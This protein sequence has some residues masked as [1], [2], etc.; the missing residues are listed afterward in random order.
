MPIE[1]SSVHTHTVSWIRIVPSPLGIHSHCVPFTLNLPLLPK[2]LP[3]MRCVISSSKA[4]PGP[5]ISLLLQFPLCPGKLAFKKD[6]LLGS[7][8][9][10]LHNY[11]FPLLCIHS[12]LFITLYC[13]MFFSLSLQ[14]FELIKLDENFFFNLKEYTTLDNVLQKEFS[15]YWMNALMTIIKTQ[16][17]FIVH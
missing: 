6:S 16:R 15:V 11:L 8:F 10:C 4:L 3:Y 14:D 2:C 13:D 1:E 9:Y 17:V 7:S 5:L 12:L